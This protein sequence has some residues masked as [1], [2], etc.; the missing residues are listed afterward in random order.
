[1]KHLFEHNYAEA[2]RTRLSR[3]DAAAVVMHWFL[4]RQGNELVQAPGSTSEQ[5]AAPETETQEEGTSS[6]RSHLLKVCEDIAKN[7]DAYPSP[8]AEPAPSGESDADDADEISLSDYQSASIVLT[9][10]EAKKNS[11]YLYI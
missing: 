4:N 1:M 2:D 5:A 10:D 9:P 3:P 6:L 11:V 7:P 8:T